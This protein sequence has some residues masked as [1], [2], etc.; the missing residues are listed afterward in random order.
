MAHVPLLLVPLLSPSAVW[1]FS[2]RKAQLS[3]PGPPSLSFFFSCQRVYSFPILWPPCASRPL[4]TQAPL[5]ALP[6]RPG[7]SLHPPLHPRS[8]RRPP[9]WPGPSLPRPGSLT[10]FQGSIR[11]AEP[12]RRTETGP[13]RQAAGAAPT[14]RAPSCRPDGPHRLPVLSGRNLPRAPTPPSRTKT[15]KVGGASSGPLH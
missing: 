9:A 15:P 10:G 2:P 7:F 4:D 11:M 8:G 13:Q 14:G 12:V 3:H 6:E 1:F 5:P